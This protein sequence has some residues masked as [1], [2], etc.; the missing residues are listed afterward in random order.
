MFK[1]Y[2]KDTRATHKFF[3]AFLLP[4][5]NRYILLGNFLS[6]WNI[7]NINSIKK[8]RQ[9]KAKKMSIYV[10]DLIYNLVLKNNKL[11]FNIFNSLKDL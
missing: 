6:T 2:K 4:T 7:F 1:V 9:P 11:F 3:S 10:M 8:E 5:L